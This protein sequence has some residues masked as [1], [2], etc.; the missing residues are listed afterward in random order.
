MLEARGEHPGLVHVISA[1]EACDCYD[2]G[3]TRRRTKPS[4]VLIAAMSAL[5]FPLYGRRPRP[6]LS[7]RAHLGTLPAAILLQR[8]Q[9]AGAAVEGGGGIDFTAADNA[10]VRI[11]DSPRAQEI[12]DGFSPDRLHAVLDRYAAR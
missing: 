8:P 7:A 5:L 1:M 3:T 10:F 11:A 12:A 9:L 6:G 2:P 4:C